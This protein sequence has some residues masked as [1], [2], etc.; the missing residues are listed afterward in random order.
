MSKRENAKRYER[1]IQAANLA[2]SVAEGNTLEE[3]GKQAGLSK[4]ATYT[5]ASTDEFAYAAGRYSEQM[6]SL[7]ERRFASSVNTALDV[8]EQTM[9]AGAN[10]NVRLKAAQLV[11]DHA[12]KLLDRKTENEDQIVKDL[13]AEDVVLRFLGRIADTMGPDVILRVAGELRKNNNGDKDK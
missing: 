8:I 4:Y 9:T 10:D 1:R 3:A 11:L 7:L 6:I 5:L 2:K 13:P 12:T